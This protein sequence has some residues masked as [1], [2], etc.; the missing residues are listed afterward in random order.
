MKKVLLFDESSHGVADPLTRSGSIDDGP[1]E[2]HGCFFRHAEGSL[3]KD[4]VHIFGGPSG[5]GQF[6]I[7]D[8]GRAVGG[9]TRKN[10]V[11]QGLGDETSETGFNRVSSHAQEHTS[12][13]V[14]GAMNGLGGQLQ[15]P[16][17]EDVRQGSQPSLK[18]GA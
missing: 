15:I 10:P 9:D 16:G 6:I 3:R 13:L 5:K 17:R 12:A 14:A 8:N 2:M 7:V 4:S 1:V 18:T 11:C